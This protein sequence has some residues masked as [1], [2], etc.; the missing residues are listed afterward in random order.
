VWLTWW[1]L[2][3]S[4]WVM[5][6]NSLDAD[7]LLAG[8]GTAALAAAIAELAGY[9]AAARP[10][11]R[12]E[13]LVPA[14]RLPVSLVRDTG[15]LFAALWRR[16]VHGVDPDSEFMEIPVRFGPHSMAGLTR[17]ALLEAGESFAPNTLV[18]GLDSERGVMVVHHL[19]P[20]RKEG[21]P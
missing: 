14:L 21:Q 18:L 20:P 16:L 17:R 5:L 3:M 1:I 6:D 9:Q 7:E 12:I 13:W 11:V 4:G 2:L 19:V 10:R 15:I 8:A